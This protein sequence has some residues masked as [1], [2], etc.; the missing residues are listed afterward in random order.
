[1]RLQMALERGLG[2]GLDSLFRSTRDAEQQPERDIKKL[3]LP[4]LVPGPH[5]PRKYFEE[6]S[7]SELSLSIRNQGIVQPLIVRP[8]ADSVPQMYEIVAGERRWRAAKLA[9]LTEVPVVIAAYDDIEAMTV[10]L[11]ENLQRENLNPLEEAEALS[12]LK[13][14]HGLSQEELAVRLGKSRSAVA[15]SLR[16]LQLSEKARDAL[17]AGKISAGHARALLA[18]SDEH[19]QTDLLNALLKL[20]LSVRECEAAA[21]FWKKKGSLPPGLESALSLREDDAR[22]AGRQS[23]KRAPK[24]AWLKDIQKN[25]RLT[26]MQGACISG[27][28]EKGRIALPYSSRGELEFL[29]DLL[30]LGST[31][32]HAASGGPETAKQDE[33]W[34]EAEKNMSGEADPVIAELIERLDPPVS[35]DN[36][37]GTR[38]SRREKKH[39]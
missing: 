38:N 5:Q 36:V 27:T 1:M 4:Q 15:N 26:V 35:I 10:A 21:D 16:L 25:L 30:G 39:A 32:E 23:A 19:A 6:T 7:L 28:E 37:A 3:A 8:K 13:E 22:E 18:I 34:S 24:T 9:G 14:A 11:V 20:D 17:G 29:L 31:A 12:T 33:N 2:K